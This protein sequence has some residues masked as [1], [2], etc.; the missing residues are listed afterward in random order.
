MMPAPPPPP[1]INICY[2]CLRRIRVSNEVAQSR[3]AVTRAALIGGGACCSYEKASSWED[4]LQQYQGRT[5]GWSCFPPAPTLKKPPKSAT[6]T[7]TAKK[8]NRTA[9]VPSGPAA[10]VLD[11]G[12]HSVKVGLASGGGEAPATFLSVW[13][14]PKR[15]CGGGLNGQLPFGFAVGQAAIDRR[16]VLGLQWPIERG[17]PTDWDATERLWR[18]AFSTALKI[19][20]EKHPPGEILQSTCSD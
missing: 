11:C 15:T 8:A 12:S 16:G 9:R 18:H 7:H 3:G 6:K 1:P 10:V 20:P 19:D 13:G 5:K 14:A 2:S 17:R 4:V